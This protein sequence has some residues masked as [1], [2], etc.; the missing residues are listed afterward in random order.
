MENVEPLVVEAVKNATLDLFST[1][2]SSS[3][4]TGQKMVRPGSVSVKNLTP[5]DAR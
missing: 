5:S 3:L 2:M 1:M 4:N